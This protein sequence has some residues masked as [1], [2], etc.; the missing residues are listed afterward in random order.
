MN[1]HTRPEPTPPPADAVLMVDDEPQ[2]RKWFER[3]YGDEFRVWTASG[4]DEALQ[5]LA[6]RG[7][8][9]AV[10]LTD[11]RMPGRDGVALLGEAQRAHP[12]IAR[13]LMSAYADKSVAVAAVNQGHVEQILEK[14]L[15]EGHTRE[16]LR[17][18]LEASRQ[19]RRTQTLLDQRAAALRETLG[20]LAHE[21]T[22]PLATV[23]GYLTALQHHHQAPSPVDAAAAPAARPGP[24]ADMLPLIEAA[25]RRTEFAQSL[26]S[27]FVQSA[28]D[29]SRA[30]APVSLQAAELLRSV[31]EAYP[32]EGTEA[33]CLQLDLTADF[34]LPGRRDLLYLVV[35][36][37]VK[38]A[39]QALRDQ[40]TPAPRLTLALGRAPYAPG[41]LPQPVIHVS[42]N[43]PGIAPERLARLTHA[44][45]TDTPDAPG[46][47]G[48]LFC[49]RVM[50]GLGGDLR[51]QAPAGQGTTVTLYFPSPPAPSDPVT[52]RE[53]P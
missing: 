34:V 31:Q 1:H 38:N 14:P 12:H 19:R 49:R 2:A 28:R 43:G 6:A 11:Y 37:L 45:A 18:A 52:P 30:S 8:E 9:V 21:V 51:L 20:F 35:C 39:L 48:L 7:G 53:T 24:V 5:M 13:L 16:A 23:Q 25:Q 10:L 29:A 4:T 33:A 42:D 41:L 32:F 50:S 40:H 46:G 3:L 17:G 26:M 44:P 27:S 36:T 15:D 47:M 22:T